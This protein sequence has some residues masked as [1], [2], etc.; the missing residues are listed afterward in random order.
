[1][2]H[3]TRATLLAALLTLPVTLL[4][5][6]N[7]YPPSKVET[8]NTTLLVDIDHRPATSLDGEWHTI[9][10]PYATGLY[11]FHHVIKPNGYFMNAKPKPGGGPVEYDFSISPTLKVPGDWNTQRPDLFYY[12]GPIWYQKDFQHTA[13][14]NTRTFNHFG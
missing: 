14:P 5:Q 9:V 6:Y 12:E 10:D 4:A 2:I 3:A 7:A 1:M 11:D 13:K 8:A